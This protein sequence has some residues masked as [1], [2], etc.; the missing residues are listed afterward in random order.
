[1]GADPGPLSADLLALADGRWSAWRG[2]DPLPT[3][4][5]VAEQLGDPLEPEPHGGVFAG[6]PT[7]FRRYAP[8]GAL[9]FVIV[10]YEG[11]QAV[12]V[13]IERPRRSA[14]ERA[15]RAADLI[16]P[17]GYGEGW[18]QHVF[19]GIGLV[20]HARAGAG[21]RGELDDVAMLIGLPPF[22]PADFDHDPVRHE[23]GTHRHE[24]G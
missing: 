10:W 2:L 15:L 6:S 3:D 11:P 19:A 22:D 23:G 21:D 5:A 16:L 13:Q 8:G 9:P 17:S 4:E 1:M 7:M 24:R 20:L 18:E 12:A 14:D